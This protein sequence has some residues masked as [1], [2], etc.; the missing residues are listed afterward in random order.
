MEGRSSGRVDLAERVRVQHAGTTFSLGRCLSRDVRANDK[1]RTSGDYTFNKTAQ[2]GTMSY[3]AEAKLMCHIV[4]GLLPFNRSPYLGLTN[5]YA[6]V[7]RQDGNASY[8]AE[9]STYS[10]IKE[11]V[12]LLFAVLRMPMILRTYF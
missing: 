10:N 6:A 5:P 1:E 4:L 12:V 2:V 7:S 9:W 11:Q 3:C 8:Y